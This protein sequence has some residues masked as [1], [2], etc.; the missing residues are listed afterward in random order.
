ML[1]V[2]KTT[3]TPNPTARRFHLNQPLLASGTLDFPTIEAAQSN[4]LAR[5]LFE[6]PDVIAVFFLGSTVTVNKEPEADWSHL[7]TPIADII[8][9]E[10]EI[11]LVPVA[12]SDSETKPLDAAPL[13][14]PGTV[15]EGYPSLTREAQGLRLQS[16]LDAYVRPG[17][18]GDGGDLLLVDW[19]SHNA[20][21]RYA[22]ACGSCPTSTTGTLA[23]IEN[24]L[25]E[26]VFA[27][28]TVHL[29]G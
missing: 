17:L 11:S 21:V 6:L 26:K 12:K 15:G 16:V 1:K 25:R 20:I 4:S 5:R 27:E 2:L 8:E 28:L 18:Q 22:G 7:I 24:A 10:N 29:A 19:D 14:A 9:S 3:E 13:A 23:F